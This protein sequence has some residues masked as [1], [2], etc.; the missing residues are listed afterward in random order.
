MNETRNT[1][2]QIS[3]RGLDSEMEKKMELTKVEIQEAIDNLNAEYE[4]MQEEAKALCGVL[5]ELYDNGVCL[6]GSLKNF[7]NVRA[8]NGLVLGVEMKHIINTNKKGKIKSIIKGKKRDLMRD[9]Q[10]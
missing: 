8:S 2:S 7:K 9:L 10:V 1:E 3:T 4:V 5:K 6:L